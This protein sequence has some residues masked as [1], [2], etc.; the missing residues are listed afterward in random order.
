MI[1]EMVYTA[2]C[3]C[4]AKLQT[5]CMAIASPSAVVCTCGKSYDS[6][7]VQMEFESFIVN[8]NPSSLPRHRRI[9]Q[10][11]SVAKMLKYKSLEESERRKAARMTGDR[12][13]D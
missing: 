3:S 9:K 1:Q 5:I 11:M 12:D 13:D 6:I 8:R 10:P 4:G 2:V 7:A